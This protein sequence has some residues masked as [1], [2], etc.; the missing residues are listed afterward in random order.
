VAGSGGTSTTPKIP[1]VPMLRETDPRWTAGLPVEAIPGRG[2]VRGHSMT[3]ETRWR[4]VTMARLY[5]RCCCGSAR[6]RC[7][8]NGSASSKADRLSGWTRRKWRLLG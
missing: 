7:S 4:A 6:T 1:L 8:R 2:E 5:S 3:F